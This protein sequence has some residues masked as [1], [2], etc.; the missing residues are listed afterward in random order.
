MAMF[1]DLLSGV[2]L[3]GYGYCA[4]HQGEVCLCEITLSSSNSCAAPKHLLLLFRQ[5]KH[6]LNSPKISD[7]PQ[8]FMHWWID[9]PPPTTPAIAAKAGA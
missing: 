9:K 2:E 8:T 6:R 7:N 4:T 1:M 5:R 3:W